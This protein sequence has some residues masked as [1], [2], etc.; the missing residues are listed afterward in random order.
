MATKP[1]MPKAPEK[2]EEAGRA[3]PWSLR[4]ERGPAHAFISDFWS[5]ELRENAS[6][7]S[8]VPPSVGL[9]RMP[10]LC[11][12]LQLSNSLIHPYNKHG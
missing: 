1:G 2:L 7:L 11:P 6:F 3:L 8:E 5:P 10:P 12:V 9:Q 4:R